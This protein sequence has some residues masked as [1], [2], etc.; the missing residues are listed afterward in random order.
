MVIKWGYVGCLLDYWLL[1]NNTRTNNY[2]FFFPDHQTLNYT[3]TQTKLRKNIQLLHWYNRCAW[4]P[5]TALSILASAKWSHPKVGALLE[6]APWPSIA[7][8]Q[9]LEVHSWADRNTFGR[10]PTRQRAELS[11]RF[12]E[13]RFGP[14]FYSYPVGVSQGPRYTCE[15]MGIKELLCLWKASKT[16]RY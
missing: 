11:K 9:Q 12:F 3:L 8:S 6:G 7:I 14:N 13:P 10:R 2:V 1:F 4:L 15:G 5:G 16:F